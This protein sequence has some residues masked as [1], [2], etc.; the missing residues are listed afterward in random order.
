MSEPKPLTL[1]TAFGPSL[2]RAVLLAA[3]P[4]EQFRPDGNPAADRRSLVLRLDAERAVVE[5]EVSVPLVRSWYSGGGTGYCSTIDSNVLWKWEQ[6]RWSTEEFSERRVDMIRHIFGFA[7][8]RPEDDELWMCTKGA[9]FH[10]AAG[11]WTRQD[12]AQRFPYQIHGRSSSEVYIGGEALLRYDG[13]ALQ[14]LEAPPGDQ[15]SALWVTSD[16]RL[17]AGDRKLSI[18]TAAGKWERIETPIGDYML[19]AELDG[20]VFAGTSG[21]GVVTVHPGAVERSSPP[22]DVTLLVA[23]GDGLIAIGDEQS[24]AYDG[25]RWWKIQMPECEAF[26]RLR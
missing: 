10:R 2:E 18:S 7:G 14:E 15:P 21:D 22:F 3:H 19:M 17:I 12:L 20:R 11:T 26:A 5:S 24:M 9:L 8:D 4:D 6:G 1:V 13:T 23:V 16:D 25:R